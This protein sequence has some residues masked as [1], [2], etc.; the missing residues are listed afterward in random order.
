[1]MYVVTFMDAECGI[2]AELR[3]EAD[4]PYYALIQAKEE[5]DRNS[6]TEPLGALSVLPEDQA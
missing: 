1:M 6:A 4:T 3:V 5:Y 2:L